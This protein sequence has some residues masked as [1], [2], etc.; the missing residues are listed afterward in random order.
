MEKPGII[1]IG[2]ALVDET[3]QCYSQP[4]QRTSNPAKLHRSMGGVARNIAH[5]LALLENN[6]ELI[7]HFGTDADGNWLK[8]ECLKS[9]IG[10]KN[11]STNNSNT[12]KYTAIISPKGELYT[13]AVS[14]Q[15]ENQ[16]T[17]EFLETKITFL[18]TASLILMD[19]N[20]SKV[21]LEWIINFCRNEEIPCIIE[22]VSVE[23]AGR[24]KDV[25]LNNVLLITPNMDELKTITHNPN[26]D[27]KDI[28]IKNTLEK[29]IQFL[30]VRNGK[31]GSEIFSE[32][33]Y[34]KQKAPQSKVIDTTGAGDAA[35]AG[36]LHA[37]LNGETPEKCVEYG[38]AMAKIVLE[39]HGAIN[40]KLNINL[41]KENL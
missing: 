35:L 31:D 1:C 2:A 8:T 9:G 41:L 25:N 5:Q 16:I 21:S 19:C 32:D 36:W 10:I 22:P 17:P 28:L 27:S 15:F 34:H 7:T 12:G 26:G 24:L 30:W 20:L 3:Y 6:V 29:G 40:N 37:H 38:H 18:K 33:L 13:A 11:S 4:L 14:T 23:K 39:V